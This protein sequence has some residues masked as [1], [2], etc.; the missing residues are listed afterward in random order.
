MKVVVLI[1]KQQEE[2]EIYGFPF[3]NVFEGR[4]ERFKRKGAPIRFAFKQ[5]TVT[6]DL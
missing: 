2:N 4:N 6:R 5:F 1:A 3:K